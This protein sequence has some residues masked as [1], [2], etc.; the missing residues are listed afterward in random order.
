MAAGGAGA[1]GT[2]GMRTKLEAAAQGGDGGHRHGAVLRP[3]CR[4]RAR[5]WPT[6]QLHGTL[7]HA[8]GD[9]LRARKQWLRH[10]PAVRPRARRRRRRRA[11]RRRGASLLPGGVIGGRGRIRSRRR[12]RSRRRHRRGADCARGLAQYSAGEIQRIAG[13]HSGDIEA[14]LGFRYGEAVIH[15]DDLV[16]LATE[17]AE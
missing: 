4:R 6:G 15:R 11:L 2:G 5:R 13:R 8:Q 3:R 9:R 17:T 7:V 16:V 14:M 10:A 12:D 1:L